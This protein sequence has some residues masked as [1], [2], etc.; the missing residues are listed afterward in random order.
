MVSKAI[1]IIVLQPVSVAQTMLRANLPQNRNGETFKSFADVFAFTLE[2]EGFLG[3]FKG[4]GPT[5]FKAVTMQGLLNILKE[6]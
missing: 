1:A 5:L 2:H 3:L 4:L 6:R